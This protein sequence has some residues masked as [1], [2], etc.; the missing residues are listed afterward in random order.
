MF[1][2]PKDNPIREGMTASVN[3]ITAGASNVLNIPV[4]AVRNV[5]GK[6]SVEI[7]GG[8]FVPVTTGFTDGKSVEIISGLNQG[9]KV[10]Y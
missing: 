7:P 3:F 9:D 1:T 8:T 5:S 10:I 6:P 2:N 4:N